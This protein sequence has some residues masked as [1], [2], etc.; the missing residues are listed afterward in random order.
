MVP[1]IHNREFSGREGVDRASTVR[2][3]IEIWIVMDDGNA[4]PRKA[5]IELE[6]IGTH[7][8][9]AVECRDRVFRGECAPAS[10][11]IDER[12]RRVRFA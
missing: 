4:V 5:D 10:V 6:P 8:H 7:L 12:M 3:A 1:G 2:A 9:A 11:R